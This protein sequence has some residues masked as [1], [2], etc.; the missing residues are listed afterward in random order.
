MLL[1]LHVDF[2]KDYACSAVNIFKK[3]QTE[4]GGG[5]LDLHS[6]KGFSFFYIRMALIVKCLLLGS[7]LVHV[8]NENVTYSTFI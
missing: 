6:I 8:G 7:F 5:G 1:T 4:R 2:N 3:F